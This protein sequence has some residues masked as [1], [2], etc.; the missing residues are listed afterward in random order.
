MSWASWLKETPFPSQSPRPPLA[1]CSAWLTHS[2]GYSSH[3]S[4]LKT[5]MEIA[6][7]E[8]PISNYLF[9]LRASHGFVCG[10]YCDLLQ[11]RDLGKAVSTGLR[12]GVEQA[13]IHDTL[14]LS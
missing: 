5:E 6:H 4:G 1:C 12:G 9:L 11:R 2:S 14:A 3:S 10:G 7:V 8:I 13:A